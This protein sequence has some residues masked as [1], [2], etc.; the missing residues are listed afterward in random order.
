MKQDLPVGIQSFPKLRES[1]CIYVDKTPIIFHLLNSGGKIFFLS[2][3][4]RFGKSMTVSTLKTIYQGRK[5]LFEGLW[6]YDKWNWEKKHPVIHI[7]MASLGYS[8]IGLSKALA[9][10]CQNVANEFGVTLSDLPYNIL[11]DELI[12]KTSK[13]HGKVVILIDEYDKP[14]IDNLETINR[15]VAEE[16]RNVLRQFYACVKDNDENI[17][18]FF[19][20]GVSKFSHTGIFSHL[21]HLRDLTLD[22]AFATIVGYTQEE[23]EESFAEYIKAAQLKMGYDTYDELIADIKKWYNGYSWDATSSVYNP[24]SVLN[25]FHLKL[26]EAH[27][28]K[29]GSPKFLIDLLKAAKFFDFNKLKVR[30]TILGSYEIENLDI[31][32][33]MF[34]TGYLTVKEIDRRKGIYVLDYPNQEVAQ[35]MSSEILNIMTG[36]QDA[37]T[38]IFNLQEAFEGN[39]LE[40]IMKILNAMVRDIPT[41]LMQQDREAFFHSLLHIMFRYLGFIMD[42]E[43]FTSNGRLDAVV[44]TGTHI[45]IFEFKIKKTAQIALQQILEKKYAENYQMLNKKIIAIGVNFDVENKCIDDWA[46]LEV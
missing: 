43:I 16:N 29:T 41:P 45:Y 23:L 18:L 37:D 19:M 42:S 9:I 44:K 39:D 38:P 14:I 27:W 33:I 28:F 34:Q 11:F 2:R 1:N 46:S 26:F 21:N 5:E 36:K 25:F 20:T 13:K 30:D 3:P 15:P 31:R 22:D 35:A 24:Y 40:R 17:E 6:I 12:K 10:F 8:E 32:T 7:P 4:R